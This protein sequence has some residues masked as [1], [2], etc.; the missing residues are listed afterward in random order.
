M[1]HAQICSH[2]ESSDATR[3]GLV[4]SYDYECDHDMSLDCGYIYTHVDIYTH[5]YIHIYLYIIVFF[6]YRHYSALLESRSKVYNK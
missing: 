1:R 2:L 3:I 6:R 5:L 4:V